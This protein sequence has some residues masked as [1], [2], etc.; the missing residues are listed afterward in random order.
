MSAVYINAISVYLPNAPIDNDNM[1]AVLGQVG[2]KPSR[3]RRT[4][5]RSNG[6]KTRYYAVNPE[7]GKA[8]HT[9]A[10]LTAEAVRMLVARNFSIND[11]DCLSCGTTLPDQLMPN[12]AVMTHGELGNTPCEVVAT[13]GVCIAGISA[14]K[15]AYLGVAAGEFSNA[16][17]TGSETMSAVMRSEN[18]EPELSG[19]VDTLKAQPQIAFEKDFL[20][21]MLSD[22]AGAML[23][24]PKPNIDKLSLQINWIF[25]RSYANEMATCMYSGAAKNDDG[26]IKS[27]KEFE[28]VEW[29]ADS[30]FSIKQ[31][32]K[33]LNEFIISYTVEK[34]LTEIIQKKGLTAKEIDYFVPHYSSAFF[35]EKVANGL[36]KIGFEIPYERWFT[37]LSSKGNT[38]SAAIYILLE[39]LFNSGNLK[40]GQKILC[41]VPESGRFSSAFMLLTVCQK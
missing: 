34:I 18:F 41:Y 23:L 6:I 2:N 7:T 13:A 35:R 5:L 9:N 26:S 20:R 38:G 4:I 36:K 10:Q 30:I 1:E 28:P 24:Q 14:M 39:E 33:L 3:A 40:A 8:T 12:H 11:I 21:W 16:V 17:A 29:L 25:E 37:N 22:G 31:D 32:V 27:W 19:H 15:Y